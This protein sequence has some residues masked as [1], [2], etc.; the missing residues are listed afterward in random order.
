MI[1]FDFDGVIV[2][3]ERLA[4]GLLARLL[5]AE[6]IPMD[7]AEATRLFTGLATVDCIARVHALTGRR[8]P[9]DFADTLEAALLRAYDTE[10]RPV[11][12]IEAVLDRLRVPYCIASGSSPR[13]IRHALRRVGLAHRFGDNVFSADEVPRRKPHPDVFL[14]AAARRGIDPARCAVIEDSLPGVIA[15]RAAGMPVFALVGSVDADTLAAAGAEPVAD[16]AALLRH[17]A[18]LRH[19]DP[20]ATAPR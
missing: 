12:G 18:F 15:A 7:V 8:L 17:P 13:K 16:H 3:S 1:V 5:T 19:A 6:G 20:G 14:H 4:N 2:D 11:P 10:L 9:E